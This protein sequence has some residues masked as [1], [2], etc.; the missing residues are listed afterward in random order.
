MSKMGRL[1]DALNEKEK[2][3]LE[4]AVKEKKPAKR[5]NHDTTGKDKLI[6]AKVNSMNYQKFAD[7]C[8]MKGVSKNSKINEL[9]SDFVLENEGI[10]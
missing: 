6:S 4:A 5:I 2:E 7:I 8:K 9:I 1:A 3:S 10:L